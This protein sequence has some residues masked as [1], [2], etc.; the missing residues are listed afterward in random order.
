MHPLTIVGPLRAG[1]TD[2]QRAAVKWWADYLYD[3]GPTGQRSGIGP[4]FLTVR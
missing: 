4:R 2:E 1:I 3:P